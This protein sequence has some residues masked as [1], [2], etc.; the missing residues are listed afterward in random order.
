MNKFDKDRGLWK[1]RPFFSCARAVNVVKY[2]VGYYEKKY[3]NR[4]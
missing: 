1:L 3:L 2:F 4:I